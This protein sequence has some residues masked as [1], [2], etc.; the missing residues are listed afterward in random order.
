MSVTADIGRAW[1]TPGRVMRR[2]LARNPGDAWGLACLIGGCLLIFISEWPLLARNAA[3]DPGI[4]L[5]ARLAGALLA[6][7][8]LMPLLAYAL[9]GLSHLLARAVGGRGSAQGARL[10]LFWSLLAASPAWLLS[11]AVATAL[12][13]GVAQA[14]GALALLL[15]L[16]LWL[17]S[18]IA[19]ETPRAVPSPQAGAAA[20]AMPQDKTETPDAAG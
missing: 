12:P 15:W 13:G 4:G 5:P 9:A 18:L 17:G 10:A 19:A 11:G 2:L 8:F 3:A 16:W 20:P 14:I 6:W 1:V 7:L